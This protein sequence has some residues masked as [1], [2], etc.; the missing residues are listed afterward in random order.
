MCSSDSVIKILFLLFYTIL[1]VMH[2]PLILS[3]VFISGNFSWPPSVV[4]QFIYS[5]NVNLILTDWE[6]YI[7]CVFEDLPLKLICH[8]KISG[9]MSFCKYFLFFKKDSLNIF[10]VFQ[11]LQFHCKLCLDDWEPSTKVPNF[12]FFLKVIPFSMS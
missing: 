8:F 6:L 11:P 3:S 12:S 1:L 9:C 7:C 4:G 2:H 5:V 10:K